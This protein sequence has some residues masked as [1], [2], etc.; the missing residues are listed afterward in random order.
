M[1]AEKL[2]HRIWAWV[3]GLLA[4]GFFL[5]GA[6]IVVDQ[7][8]EW[9]KKAIWEPHT[10]AEVLREWGF[11][12]PNMPNYLG[13]QKIMDAILAWPASF[14][15]MLVSVLFVLPWY[16]EMEKLQEIEM[17]ERGRRQKQEQAARARDIQDELKEHADIS[18][19]DFDFGKQLEEVIKRK[20]FGEDDELLNEQNVT[21][22]QIKRCIHRQ[23]NIMRKRH[24]KVMRRRTQAFMRA[25]DVI[26]F[27]T[28]SEGLASPVFRSNPGFVGGGLTSGGAPEFVIPNGPIPPGAT[29]TIIR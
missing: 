1:W 29:T 18:R 5:M 3:F 19:S 8:L 15:Y 13:F 28:P 22:Q 4:A 25:Q 27:S 14:S 2:W 12:Y 16:G 11:S 7:C 20:R 10:I 26:E 24:W 23:H 9:T 17:M 21:E 6:L